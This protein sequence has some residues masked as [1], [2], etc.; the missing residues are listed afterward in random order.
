MAD[1]SKVKKPKFTKKDHMIRD[2]AN[3]CSRLGK[4]ITLNELKEECKYTK[5]MVTHH[6][7]SLGR[8]K[9]A[10]KNKYPDKFTQTLDEN[11]FSP[12]QIQSINTIVKDKK[13]FF[14]TTAVT[15]CIAN[16]VFLKCIENYCNN[17]NAAMLTLIASDPASNSGEFIDSTIDPNTIVISDVSLNSNIHINTIKLSA[18]HIDPATGLM[19]I[20]MRSGSFIYASPK[21]RLRYAAIANNSKS[22]SGK[23]IRTIMT[24]GAITDP[25]YDTSIYMG[26]RT[27]HIASNDHIMGGIIVEIQDDKEYHFRQ[28]QFDGKS[29]I[30]LGERYY[31]DKVENCS[32]EAIVLGD[33]HSGE[34]DPEAK[35]VWKEIC[36]KLNPQY[37]VMHDIFNGMA[38]NPHEK[39][40][41]TLLAQRFINGQLNSE[42]E[43]KVL[44]EDIKELL[45][46][47]PKLVIVKSNHDEFLTRFLKDGSLMDDLY[48]Q[49]RRLNLEL[50]IADIDGKDPLKYAVEKFLPQELHNS[51]IWLKRDEDFMV[52]GVNLGH[53]GDLGANGAKGNIVA[54]E[55]GYGQSV[56]GHSHSPEIL[57]GAYKVGTSTY[58]RLNYNRGISSWYQTICL[59]Y[60]NGSRQLVNNVNGHYTL[61]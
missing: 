38:Y 30:D 34:T 39:K 36:Q 23:K 27:A 61:Q 59:V 53:H 22:K 10:A 4:Y 47:A 29:F 60:P 19:R 43:F 55:S 26:D 54:M 6:F 45:K 57:H 9:E 14:I 15:G 12:K 1:K 50:A 44:C 2:Y 58:L 3:T 8:L 16:K 37:L 32:P 24:T 13:R 20:G 40:D 28:V 25:K 41:K 5:D 35:A 21:Q 17:K 56:S 31:E 48:L 52:G 11:I 18:K 51:L 42:N 7:G 49:N 33:W 46:D